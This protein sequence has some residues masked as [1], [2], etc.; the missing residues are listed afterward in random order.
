MDT[1][2]FLLNDYWVKAKINKDIKGFVRLHKNECTVYPSERDTVKLVLRGNSIALSAKK[3][4]WRNI[5]L[6]T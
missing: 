6:S 5:I 3:R 1:E 2:L 4:N